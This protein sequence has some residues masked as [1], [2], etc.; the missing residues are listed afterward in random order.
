MSIADHNFTG[1]ARQ[2]F[3]DG[4][5]DQKRHPYEQQEPNSGNVR[6]DAME[7]V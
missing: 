4:A 6:N 5:G 3:T 2:A 1:P 7:A